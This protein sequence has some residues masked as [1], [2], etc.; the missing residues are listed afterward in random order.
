[1][2]RSLLSSLFPTSLAVCALAWPAWSCSA[3]GEATL[4]HGGQFVLNDGQG[5][6]ATALLARDG[7]VVATGSLEQLA[8]REDASD[9]VRV[10]LRGGCAVPGLQDAHGHLEGYAN[11][12][13]E[14]DLY[15]L[16]SFDALIERVAAAAAK[17]PKGTWLRGRGWDQNLWESREFP[18]HLLLSAATPKHPVLLTRVDGHALLCNEAALALAGFG[19]ALD[20]EP[21]VQ[22]GR[23]FLDEDGFAT[24]IFL[25]SAM[26]LVERVCPKTPLDVARRRFLAAQ[27]KLLAF[28]LTCVH[29]MG[30]SRQTLNL[31]Q[32]LR[33]SGDLK[34]RVVAYLDGNS[35]TDAK[36]LAGFPMAPDARDMLSV[37]GVKL[38]ADGALGSRGAALLEPYSDA[39][40]ERGLLILTEDQLTTRLSVIARAGMQPAVH[41]IGDRANRIVLDAYARLS[42]AVPGFRD[43]R[44]RIEHAQ[45]VAPRD[46][47]RFPAL[48][49]VPSM[50]PTHATSDMAWVV[51][52]LG[53]ERANGAYAWR[54]LAPELGRLAFGSDFPVE[55]PDP[56]EG[57]FAARTRMKAGGKAEETLL[58]EQRLDGAA[59]LSGF[60]SGAAWASRQDERRGRLQ[61]GYACD[62]TVLGL[63]PTQCAPAELL[64]DSV[65]LVVIN[66][67]VAWRAPSKA[68]SPRD[69]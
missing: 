3:L 65:R 14:I 55:S 22:G 9:A 47:P 54:A 69:G 11:A 52:R 42:V 6:T 26:D 67:V 8:A 12:L 46:W 51:Q 21:K 61:P 60:T 56:L 30:T 19:D 66:G 41:A 43:L 34:L 50:Q 53:A 15:G 35:V 49:V 10:D 2:T 29:D 13:E 38:Y 4:Y 68:A 59:A 7:F 5:G 33:A 48:G 64:K 58:P 25:D 62:L 63:D 28:G 17:V 20:S 27:E 45:V 1:M 44:P 40:N 18:H 37:P 57:I 23:V 36:S 31:L 32:D 24:G 16:S 39:P